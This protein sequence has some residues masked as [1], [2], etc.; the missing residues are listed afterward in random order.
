M[1]KMKKSLSSFGEHKQWFINVM[2]DASERI[3]RG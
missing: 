2:D 3:E 1:I